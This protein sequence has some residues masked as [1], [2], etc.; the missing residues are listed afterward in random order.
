[1][2]QE[3]VLVKKDI[4]KIILI[5]A[6]MLLLVLTGLRKVRKAAVIK[7]KKVRF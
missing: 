3:A 2:L 1:M 7:M 5:V 6:L 4:V